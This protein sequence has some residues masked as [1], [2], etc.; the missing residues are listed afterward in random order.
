MSDR[1][2]L[3]GVLPGSYESGETFS[4]VLAWN[5]YGT[6]T[7][8]PRPVLRI[9]AEKTLPKNADRIKE[10]LRKLIVNPKDSKRNET[11]LL[12]SLGSQSIAEA[13]RIITAGGE[14]QVNAPS[15]IRRK[16]AGKPPLKD[17]G[18]LMKKLAYEVEG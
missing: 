12:Q 16:G 2:V 10:F 14:L 4:D 11:I 6:E 5:H 13:K 8:P 18:E 7:I 3:L 17:T 15:T 1:K 9:A